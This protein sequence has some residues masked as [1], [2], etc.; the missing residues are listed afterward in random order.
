MEP[1]GGE[2]YHARMIRMLEALWGEGFLSPGYEAA[3]SM[4][5]SLQDIVVENFLVM[6]RAHYHAVLHLESP[7]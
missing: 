1:D 4:E 3:L 2:L 7:V 6:I 5:A